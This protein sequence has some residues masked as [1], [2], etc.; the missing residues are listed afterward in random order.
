MSFTTDDKVQF[1]VPLSRLRSRGIRDV[2]TNK[3]FKD[4][5]GVRFQDVVFSIVHNDTY[6]EDSILQTKVNGLTIE[7]HWIKWKYLTRA[8]PLLNKL[9][10]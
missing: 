10:K 9:R 5:Y 8:T 1:T 7:T 2:H 4:E 6:D 3:Q